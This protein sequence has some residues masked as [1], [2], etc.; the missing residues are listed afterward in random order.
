MFTD[1]IRLLGSELYKENQTGV[2][3]KLTDVGQQ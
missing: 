2:F 1:R 3:Q